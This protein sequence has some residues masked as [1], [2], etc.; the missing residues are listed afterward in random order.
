MKLKHMSLVFVALDV[1]VIISIDSQN[2]VNWRVIP[3]AAPL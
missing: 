3:P 2:M 1:D